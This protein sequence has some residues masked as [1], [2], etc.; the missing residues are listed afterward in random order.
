[1]SEQLGKYMTACQLPDR[2]GR[3]THRWVIRSRD[4][5]ELGW[6]AWEPGWRQYVFQPDIL[7]S[8]SAGCQRDLA[9]FQD[10]VNAAHRESKHE[11]PSE[12][13][14]SCCGAGK[15]GVD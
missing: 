9:D 6:I 10:R 14:N 15:R 2:P 4:L 11:K 1:M 7:T 13:G 5:A 3:K 12:S 8:F